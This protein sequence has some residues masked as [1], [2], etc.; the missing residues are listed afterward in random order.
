MLG[1]R[2]SDPAVR[3]WAKVDRSQG[4]DACWP[5]RAGRDR[6]GY[7]KFWVRSGVGETGRT[8]HASRVAL[9]L[10]LGRPVADDKSA[11][12]HC[13]NPPCC[14]PAHLYEGSSDANANDRH[15]RGRDPHGERH[16]RA[17]L[18]EELVR[19]IR[20]AYRPNTRGAGPVSLARRFGLSSRTVRNVVY[21]LAW[22]HIRPFSQRDVAILGGDPGL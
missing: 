18:T 17:R 8:V 6:Q 12:H 22:R 14:N 20:A 11:C 3:F 10:F 5:W 13:D 1:R 21:R 16:G 19:Q 4:P 9:G 7:G 15:S 2:P